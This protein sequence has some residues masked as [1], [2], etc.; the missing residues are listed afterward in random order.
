MAKY[1]APLEKIYRYFSVPNPKAGVQTRDGQQMPLWKV[2]SSACRCVCFR[3]RAEKPET[4]AREG[5]TLPSV[6]WLFGFL[7]VLLFN[8]ETIFT[9]T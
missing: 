6:L 9:L 2:R 7:L 8:D 1:R 4:E 3:L 5:K